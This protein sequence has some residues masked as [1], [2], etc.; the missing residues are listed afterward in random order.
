MKVDNQIRW[1][2]KNA[3]RLKRNCPIYW[4]WSKTSES[5]KRHSNKVTVNVIDHIGRKWKWMYG[6]SKKG[7][8]VVYII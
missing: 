2:G 7:E 1:K 3:I 4:L 6:S 8:A 5:E